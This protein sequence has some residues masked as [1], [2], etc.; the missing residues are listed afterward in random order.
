MKVL[1]TGND[2]MVI[3]WTYQNF[4]VLCTKVDMALA[5]IDNN[6]IVGACFFQAHNGP[7]VELSY[8]GPNTLT[9]DLVRQIARIA[10]DHLGVSRITIRT[11]K[12]NKSLTK[13]AHKLGFV[14]EG[15]RHHAYGDEDAVM[16]GLFGEKLARL[17]GRVLQ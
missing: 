1:A 10:V 16:F 5:V 15:I 4:G 13:N 6:A 8:F 2:E 7:D 12:S 9:L 14:Y 17:A 11:A 3:E